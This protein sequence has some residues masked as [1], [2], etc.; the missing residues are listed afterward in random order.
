MSRQWLYSSDLVLWQQGQVFASWSP[1]TS[2]GYDWSYYQDEWC[3]W[4]RLL[5]LLYQLRQGWTTSGSS[6]PCSSMYQILK[7]KLGP[8]DI[9]GTENTAAKELKHSQ[10]INSY[11]IKI[12]VSQTVLLKGTFL[13]GALVF[14]HY[15]VQ[16][17][18]AN[19]IYNE[20]KHLSFSVACEAALL[21]IIINLKTK[22]KREAADGMTL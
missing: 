17:I 13:T 10:V 11:K 5:T 8:H 9:R 6:M 18:C 21:Y 3:W 4:I 2:C 20:T 22:N 14:I 1:S 19:K 7:L 16:Y 12:L 15:I